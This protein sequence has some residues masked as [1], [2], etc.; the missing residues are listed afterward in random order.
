M[1][2]LF[3]ETGMP[4]TETANTEKTRINREL[5]TSKTD[6]AAANRQVDELESQVRST[7]GKQNRA[8]EALVESDRRFRRLMEF[9]PDAM[10]IKRADRIVF[11]NHLRAKLFGASNS[12]QV[13]GKSVFDFI[14]SDYH[15][16]MTER[17]R[18]METGNPRRRSCRGIDD[19]T[20]TKSAGPE[21]PFASCRYCSMRLFVRGRS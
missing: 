3:L 9:S 21:E 20:T 14:H 11:A 5:Q 19:G 7:E 16:I 15:A 8:E 10:F 1:A 6:L 18:L 17:L 2:S 4:T 12:E 13:L